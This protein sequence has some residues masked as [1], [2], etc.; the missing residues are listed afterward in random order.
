MEASEIR[1]LIVDD[2][3][4]FAKNMA[5]ILAK[6][7]FHAEV[8]SDGL[9]ALETIR[10]E[11]EFDVMLLD[12]RMPGMNG[13]QVLQHLRTLAP[14]LEV[15]ML[16]GEATVENGIEAVRAGAFDYL[17]KPFEIDE[18]VEKIRSASVLERIR[19]RPVLWPRSTAGEIILHAFQR[20]ATENRLVE[21]LAVFNSDRRKMAGETLFISDDQDVLKG[22]LTRH[23]LVDAARKAH[24]EKH[25]IWEE[26]RSHPEW[27]PDIP[28]SEVMG[29]QAD[30]I[31]AQ[32]PLIAVAR[33]LIEN[34]I[35]SMPVVENGKIV[36]I[37]RRM[38]VLKYVEQEAEYEAHDS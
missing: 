20:L 22:S 5:R 3:T 11:A 34:G 21:A 4:I 9:E 8:A 31:T 14:E 27:L 1:V 2:E 33:H 35:Q 25:V 6:R 16:T 23:A 36:G 30:A 12:V 29:K 15:I 13:I 7:G 17:P 19:K 26:L 37:V 38:D 18:L 28:V 32:T 24:P 10:R